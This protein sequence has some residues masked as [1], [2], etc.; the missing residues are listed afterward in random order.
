LRNYNKYG[1]YILFIIDGMMRSESTTRLSDGNLE[2]VPSPGDEQNRFLKGLLKG[3][4]EVPE[5]RWGA[6]LVRIAQDMI[7]VCD[8][9]LEIQYH[10][11]SFVR[12]LGFSGGSYRGRNLL[13]FFPA[14][15]REAADAAFEELGGGRMRGI[16]IEAKF[17]TRSKPLAI[18]AEVTRSR[19]PN[20][21]F[22]YY[23][24][25][26]PTRDAPVVAKTRKLEPA[27]V[28]P[29][30]K[31]ASELFS[32]L[33]I[34]A[35]RADGDHRITQL[36]G[37]LWKELSVDCSASIG[38]DL[39]VADLTEGPEILRS[40]K[41]AARAGRRSFVAE[42]SFE[43]LRYS[44][45]VEPV[46]GPGGECTGSVGFIRA[47]S[48][49]SRVGI[50]SGPVDGTRT[51]TILVNPDTRKVATVAAKRRTGRVD[52]KPRSLTPP[53]RLTSIAD[54]MKRE[55]LPL[56]KRPTSDVTLPS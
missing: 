34:A 37:K 9:Q 12:K 19:R 13:D 4:G 32:E 55:P 20:G 10:N 43:G 33:P 23:M 2:S 54:A 5:A 6:Q 14:A 41:P 27:A 3:I 26:R 17:L 24:I 18:V 11:Q 45:T 50:E 49:A 7:I 38:V 31:A 8:D 16:E 30:L 48:A 36:F 35:W 44:V 56:P 39:S 1:I 42:V 22:Y 51:T 52:I 47:A 46:N 15:D 40:I 29:S 53:T 21:S 25:V 28:D